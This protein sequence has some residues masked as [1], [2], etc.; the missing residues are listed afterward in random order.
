MPENANNPFSFFQ[1]LKRRKVIRTTLIYLAS[2]FAI[3]EAA[4]IIFPRLGF[5]EWTLT[6]VIYL[7]GF[8][9]IT[10]IILSW[11]YDITPEGIKITDSLDRD[12]K[13]NEIKDPRHVQSAII[14]KILTFTS[15]VIITFFVVIRLVEIKSG[16]KIGEPNNRS[17]AIMPFQNLT[18]DS[19]WDYLETGISELLINSLGG[20]AE[21]SVRS[22]QKMHEVLASLGENHLASMIPSIHAEAARK[23]LS[24]FYVQGN[25][26]RVKDQIHIM[27]NLVNTN[28][29]DIE[30]TAK[31]Y[32]NQSDYI[33]L[34]DSISDLLTKHLELKSL[35]K[36][37]QRDMKTIGTNSIEAYKY[38]ILAKRA[39][40]DVNFPL[41]IKYWK[42]ALKH[43]S[44]FMSAYSDIAQLLSNSGQ[45]EK[46]EHYRHKAYQYYDNASDLN[47]TELDRSRAFREE[48]DMRAAIGYV[49]EKINL[50]A[51]TRGTWYDLGHNYR[52]LQQYE[53][54][55]EPFEK[56]IEI[57]KSW[58]GGWKW[59][60]AYYWL[61]YCYHKTGQYKKEGQ[62]YDLALRNIPGHGIIYQRKAILAL[63]KGK[64]KK[65]DEYLTH[66]KKWYMESPDSEYYERELGYTYLGASQITTAEKHF[67]KQI[68]R[69]PDE[70]IAYYD[71]GW[72]LI[73][74]DIDI[75]EG[76]RL[77]NQALEMETGTF[78]TD[79]RLADRYVLNLNSLLYFAKGVAN[80]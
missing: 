60:Y 42:E 4:D 21:L 71:L 2:A 27:L 76:M 30:W 78:S 73:K 9:L 8:G 52:L 31:S 58:G 55:I 25:F 13:E 44:T 23:T 41:A 46:A 62:I 63:M 47:K 74:E 79:S 56:A 7:L 36:S 22:S 15:I 51:N 28:N 64:G 49:K 48:K 75:D 19:S 12:T 1:E 37:G 72:L 67:R 66:F 33:Q 26:Q 34:V 77:I 61:G 38:S 5:P 50:G 43:D 10:V 69:T 24:E 32:G 3:L 59:P 14:W 54:A 70:K 29:S 39:H 20:S 17:I 68:D 45:Y 6:L 53:N 57:D 18:G 11:I 65:F 16:H 35:V 80:F 40:Y